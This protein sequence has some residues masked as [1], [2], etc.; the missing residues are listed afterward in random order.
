MGF[1]ALEFG[2]KQ[3]LHAA[4]RPASWHPVFLDIL[5]AWIIITGVAVVD[6]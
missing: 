5:A 4:E 3:S 1:V 6:D 2:S